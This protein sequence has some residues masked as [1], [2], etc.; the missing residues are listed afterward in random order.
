MKHTEFNWREPIIG[1]TDQDP[2]F[3][4][5]KELIRPNHALPTDIIP[6]AKSVIVFF[7]PFSKE[8]IESN[9]V[10]EESSRAW[11]ISNIETNNL[12]NDLN[13]HLFE[14]IS[15]K[16]FQASASLFLL[17]LKM[18]TLAYCLLIMKV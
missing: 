10:G 3:P 5:L 16:G 7:L 6:N 18:V 2:L 15:L 14:L 9:I 11:D 13:K 12:I 4:K 1:F 8:V 17:L